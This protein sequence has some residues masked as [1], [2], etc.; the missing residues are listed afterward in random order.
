MTEIFVKF[1]R[2]EIEERKKVESIRFFAVQFYIMD[3]KIQQLFVRFHSRKQENFCPSAKVS[4]LLKS[5]NKK[6]ISL[7]NSKQLLHL[8]KYTHAILLLYHHN[9]A[10]NNL[11][12]SYKN[13]QTYVNTN[14]KYV[15]KTLERRKIKKM[16]RTNSVFHSFER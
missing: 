14:E 7:E 15:Q 5:F 12:I 9:L 1:F 3:H 6:A 2:C 13:E 10:W 8:L 4:R 11:T 16:G